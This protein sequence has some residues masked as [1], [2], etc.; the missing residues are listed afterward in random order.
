MPYE[1]AAEVLFANGSSRL[2]S[3]ARC[4]IA[5]TGAGIKRTMVKNVRLFCFT[6]SLGSSPGE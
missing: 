5:A 1:L 2:G 4:R 6:D 3:S